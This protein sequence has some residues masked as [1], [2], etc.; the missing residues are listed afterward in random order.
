L[1]N[2]GLQVSFEKL[3]N[4]PNGPAAL[5]QFHN[6]GKRH[7]FL[8]AQDDSSDPSAMS[9]GARKRTRTKLRSGGLG[10]DTENGFGSGDDDDFAYG[11]KRQRMSKPRTSFRT[12]NTSQ[13][14]SLEKSHKVV[15]IPSNNDSSE[16][17]IRESRFQLRRSTRNLRPNYGDYALNDKNSRPVGAKASKRRGSGQS[18]ADSEDFDEDAARLY[19]SND[20]V[21]DNAP[22]AKSK[23]SHIGRGR[24]RPRE[25][26]NRTGQMKRRQNI[27]SS[28][29]KVSSSS[30]DR[31]EPPRRSDRTTKATKSMRELR[32]DEEI[33]ADDVV[34]D[35]RPQV[36]TIREVFKPLPPKSHFKVIHN[37]YCDVC[38]GYENNSNKGPSPLIYCQGCSTSVHRACLGARSTREHIVTKVGDQ[39]FVMQCR[40]CIGIATKKD[41]VAPRLDICQGCKSP[42]DACEPFSQRR[43]PKQE[44][45]LR[46]ENGGIDPITPVDSELLNNPAIILFRCID[47]HRGFHFEHLPLSKEATEEETVE[48]TRDLRFAE[49]SQTWKCKDC[50]D[51]PAKVQCLVAWRPANIDNY[52]LGQTL[53]LVSDGDKD[54]LVKWEDLSYFRC[55]WMP[56]AWVWGVTAATTRASF[57]RRNEGRNSL[58]KMRKD[59]AIPEEFLRMEIVL[60]VEY[61]SRVKTHTEEIDK[62][63]VTEVEKVY[64]KFQGLGYDEIVWERPPRPSE[65]ERWNDFVAA[66]NEYIAGKY[67]KQPH[68]KMK[69]HIQEYRAMDFNKKILLQD[70]PACLTG[71][72]MMEYQLEGLNWLLYNYHQGKNI[73]L[74]DEMGLGKTIQVIAAIVTLVKEKPKV[75]RHQARSG[76]TLMESVLAFLSCRSEFNMSKLATGNQE[77]GSISSRCCLL[78]STEGPRC[79]HGVRVISGWLF[80]YESSCGGHILRCS[81]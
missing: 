77:M 8:S 51:A 28:R 68:A 57:A 78:R 81:S 10:D 22:K 41:F 37:K 1:L 19:E 45:K 42:G 69:E 47:C 46:E 43:T 52:I 25:D 58:P 18:S 29:H 17:E 11:A 61:S 49:Y 54:Y 62:A 59:D 73:V 70:Q 24:G 64:V 9:S 76:L 66:Y 31:P 12:T 44:E 33:F 48:D 23:N 34:N 65:V 75:R 2:F 15:G 36:I 74:A 53:D 5:D 14:K 16:N 71:G 38:S 20:Y 72:K 35:K 55:A 6:G 39:D 50:Q 32:E 21:L 60:D 3:L 13:R 27:F 79:R 80:R 7:R 63:R 56:G 67:F 40:R 30:D 26:V 4:F